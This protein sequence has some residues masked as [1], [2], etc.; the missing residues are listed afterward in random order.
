MGLP[1]GAFMNLG[2][3]DIHDLSTPLS[4]TVLALKGSRAANGVSALHGK[5]SRSMFPQLG[6]HIGHVTNGVHPTAWIAPELAELLEKHMPNWSESWTQTEMWS[7]IDKISDDELWTIRQQMRNRIVSAA[8]ERLGPDV[9]NEKALTI[10][11]ARRFA[12]YKRGDLIF[13]DPD[14]L[15]A[16]LDKGVQLVFAGKTPADKPGKPFLRVSRVCEIPRF[17]GRVFHSDMM[18]QW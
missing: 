9:L 13:S 8:R 5:V 18:Q 6:A 17:E 1:K 4:M 10:G 2:R 16:I 3:E 7:A 15:A 11:F 14:R 12:T